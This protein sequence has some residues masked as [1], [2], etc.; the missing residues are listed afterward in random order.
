MQTVAEITGICCKSFVELVRNEEFRGLKIAE[1]NACG[2]LHSYL[3]FLK[4]HPNLY[5]SE[6]LP[7]GKSGEL[8][9]GV[10]CE[11][12]QRLTYPDDY[13]DIF[14]TSETLEHAPDQ[15]EPG[16]RSTAF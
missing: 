15:I 1:I 7:D 12:L 16:E 10:R 9:D 4:D 2:T 5:Y 14:L 6:W 11:D 8:H 3:I 13:F